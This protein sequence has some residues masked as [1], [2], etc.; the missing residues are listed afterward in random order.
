VSALESARSLTA[1][2]TI[3]ACARFTLQIGQKIATMVETYVFRT[4]Q[5]WW[6]LKVRGFMALLGQGAPTSFAG[7]WSRW[8][9]ARLDP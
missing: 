7:C 8:L 3:I 1:A 4:K 2:F 6:R 9:L 5:E